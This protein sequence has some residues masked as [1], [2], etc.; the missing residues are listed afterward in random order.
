MFAWLI[1]LCLTGD[2]G[3]AASQPVP[4]PLSQPAT[5]QPGEA[6]AS[7]ADR[8]IHA[9]L[10]AMEARGES[11]RTL[12]CRVEYTVED[13]IGLSDFTKFGEI[14]YR[15]SKPNPTFFIRF[16]K[17][18][19]GGIVDRKK[20]WYLFRDRWLLEAKEASRTVIK[21][22]VIR[23]GETVDLFSLERTPFPIP[24]GQRKDEILRHFQVTL[25]PP[26]EGDP[27]NTDHLVC[28]PR[29]G[30]KLA[31]Q[32]TRLE[33]FVDRTLHL[34]VKIVA[35]EADPADRHGPPAKI[36]R[37]VFPDLTRQ[38]INPADVEELFRLPPETDP[39]KRIEEPMPEPVAPVPEGR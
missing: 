10:E 38:S 27:A 34:P 15:R 1:V 26:A 4:V 14:R 19:E 2:P 3:P 31:D 33:F 11:V 8:V 20:E 24:F 29:T 7:A 21:R 25:S 37:A 39:Y 35:Y 32:Y 16:D 12:V 5:T 22:E 30:S 13:L 28:V 6:S 17:M 18:H 9:I 23:E 36:M